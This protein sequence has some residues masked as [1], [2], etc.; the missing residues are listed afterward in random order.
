MNL[1]R[2]Q[3]PSLRIFDSPET[4]TQ[5]EVSQWGYEYNLYDLFVIIKRNILLNL[6]NRERATVGFCC[7]NRCS[8]I[9]DFHLKY[10]IRRKKVIS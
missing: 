1:E 5:L 9:K 6:Q 8:N 2:L 4:S 10:F 7:Y 3:W